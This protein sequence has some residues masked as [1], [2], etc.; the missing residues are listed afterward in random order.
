MGSSVSLNPQL[1]VVKVQAQS[2][3]KVAHFLWR[4]PHLG[5]P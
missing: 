5:I 2:Q 4:L 1:R 3:D